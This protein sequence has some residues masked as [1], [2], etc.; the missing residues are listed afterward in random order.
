MRILILK[1]AAIG[2]VIMALPMVTAAKAMAADVHITWIC[3][4]TVAP[5][6][7]RVPAINRLIVVDERTLFRGGAAARAAAVF[8]VWR[9][10]GL[11]HFD[12]VAMGNADRRYSLLLKSTR[13]D[14]FRSFRREGRPHPLPGRQHSDE[15][16]RL[17]TGVDGPSA[18]RFDL[19]A[20]R[21]PD[22]ENHRRQIDAAGSGPV[23]VIAPGG[24][25]NV[26]GDQ[27]WRRWP[28]NH[29]VALTK[30]LLQRG[31]RVIVVGGPSDADVTPRLADLNVLN[32][33]G[34]T[35]LP[36]L[37]GVLSLA[38]VIVSHDTS[39]IHLARLAKRPALGLF[40][41]TI[42]FEK[43]FPSSGSMSIWGG[44]HLPCRPCYDGV[45]FHACNDN[46]CMKS[47][48][49]NDVLAAVT[50]ILSTK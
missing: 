16:V 45:N 41:P 1:L 6:L 48:D 22:L 13:G 35:E 17:I 43:L 15:Y 18:P 3:G 26:M 32:L 11:S 23:A 8:A 19:P 25:R 27:L 30:L 12:L 34:E 47:I 29:Y 21:L 24:A 9:Q 5:L 31:F 4:E 40:G 46:Q 50:T 33:I 10:L 39:I 37:V 44:E 42:P 38:D 20:F 7:K 28:T 36:D 14:V 2:D 49:V